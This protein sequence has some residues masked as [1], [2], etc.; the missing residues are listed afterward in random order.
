M[1]V[2][3]VQQR[4]SYKISVLLFSAEVGRA[5]RFSWVR[6]SA[7]TSHRPQ[8]LVLTHIIPKKSEFLLGLGFSFSETLIVLIK[9]FFHPNLQIPAVLAYEIS[10]R[11]GSL[12]GCS[13]LRALNSIGE[14]Y[15]F[16]APLV[17]QRNVCRLCCPIL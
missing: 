4:N 15:L 3:N 13:F 1:L 17:S 11:L 10:I 2:F 7:N 14:S 9:R 16:P 6:C 8:R 5:K 12:K